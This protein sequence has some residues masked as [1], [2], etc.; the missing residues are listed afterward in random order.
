MGLEIP[1]EKREIVT[2]GEIVKSRAYDEISS[3]LAL[4]L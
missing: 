4:A 1:N 2:L 3:P